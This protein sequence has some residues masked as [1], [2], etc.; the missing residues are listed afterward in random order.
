M[1]ISMI[2]GCMA[3]LLVSTSASARVGAD[4]QIRELVE[5]F[6]VAIIAKDRAALLALPVNPQIGLAAAVD[7]ATLAKARVKRPNAKANQ[8]TSYADFVEE[9]V[10]GKARSEE[11]FSHVRISSD[12]TIGQM[13]SDYQFLED[14][15]VTNWG[16]ESWL[17][18]RTDDG[19]KIAAIA[20]SVTLPRKPT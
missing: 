3:C 20:Y 14:G 4:D 1:K 15:K 13:Y 8:I 17:L 2:L 7:P 11:T 12:G 16:H 5:R 18:I 10:T 6:R 9:I 19:W